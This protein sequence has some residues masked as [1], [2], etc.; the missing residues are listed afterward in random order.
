MLP[1]V[2]DGKGLGEDIRGHAGGLTVFDCVMTTLQTLVEEREVHTVCSPHMPHSRVAAGPEDRNSGRVVL[3]EADGHLTTQERLPESCRGNAFDTKP[4]IRGHDLRLWS[5][6]R[7]AALPLAKGGQRDEGVGAL[8]A[9]EDSRRTARALVADKV[10]VGVQHQLQVLWLV[11]HPAGHSEIQRGVDVTYQTVQEAIARLIPFRDASCQEACC[12]EQ[13][14]AR[15]AGRIQDFH[16]DPAGHRGKLT[17]RLLAVY[18]LDGHF[19]E[20]SGGR[21]KVLG[22]C[23]AQL[24]VQRN[25]LT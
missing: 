24:L 2:R 12:P 8:K 10:S 25:T 21:P 5:R 1:F 14:V 22:L 13:V 7:H 19:D 18:G 15:H 11:T 3:K 23:A 16:E 20:W 17:A 6:V 4:S 9:Q